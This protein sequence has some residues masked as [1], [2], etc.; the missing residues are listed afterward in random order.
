MY[1]LFKFGV[2]LTIKRVILQLYVEHFRDDSFPI[3]SFFVQDLN[4]CL[5]EFVIVTQTVFHDGCFVG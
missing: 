3:E 5:I 4:I 2:R 1:V